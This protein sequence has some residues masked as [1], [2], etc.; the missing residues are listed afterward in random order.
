MKENKEK[1]RSFIALGI[2]EET[3][4]LIYN[5]ISGELISLPL[6]IS[7][8]KHEN[9]HIT[10]KFL[11]DITIDQ[12]DKIKE[13]LDILVKDHSRLSL[14]LGKVGT[15]GSRSFPR[16]LW[17]NFEGDIIQLTDLANDVIKSC[18]KLGF[19]KEKRKF[20]SHLTLGRIRKPDNAAF[21]YQKIEKL[22]IPVHGF[23]GEYVLLMKSTLTPQGAIYE[24][25]AKYKLKEE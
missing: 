11:G 21:L 13:S 12:V 25:L 2:P 4:K 20:S 8:V 9:M 7:W 6:K 22:A 1:I 3:Q 15:F 17:L 23:L 10:L 24:E 5:K 19:E 16:V 14:S 18:T